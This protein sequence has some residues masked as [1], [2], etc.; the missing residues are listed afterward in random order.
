M[1]SKTPSKIIGIQ[2]SILSPEE[3]ERYSVAEITNK[4]TYNGIKPKIGGLFDPRMG[5]LEPGMVCPTDGQNYIDCPGYFGHIKLARPVFY[6]QY[7]GTIQK[8]LKGKQFIRRFRK[9]M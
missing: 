5:V 9:M 8:I 7:L 3:I 4:E 2:F 1:T 6:I